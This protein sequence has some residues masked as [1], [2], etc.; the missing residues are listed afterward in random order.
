MPSH[1][2]TVDESPKGTKKGDRLNGKRAF[3]PRAKN[4]S[5]DDNRNFFVDDPRSPVGYCSRS[6]SPETWEN[7]TKPS[8]KSEQKR[9][10]SPSPDPF[11]DIPDSCLAQTHPNK[12][13][14][15]EL[16]RIP[17]PKSLDPIVEQQFKAYRNSCYSVFKNY[18]TSPTG[19]EL[20]KRKWSMGKICMIG[21]KNTDYQ[22]TWIDLPHLRPWT[23]FPTFREIYDF[24][25]ST[26]ELFR[27]FH[28][29]ELPEVA[30][31]K[32]WYIRHFEDVTC[33][34]NPEQ[35]AK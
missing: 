33:Y 34:G 16:K 27:A 1:I 15:R 14:I 24:S 4:G 26:P 5:K 7:N 8:A 20:L 22:N 32:P 11:P 3:N 21:G 10:H 12:M 28:K 30:K 29:D 18:T 17:I 35:K 19:W 25:K 2:S 23:N 31:D 13:M 9:E 6:T